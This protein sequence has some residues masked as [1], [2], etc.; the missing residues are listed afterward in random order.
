MP[1]QCDADI[2]ISAED[3]AHLI[4]QQF[5]ELAP[6]Q[7][8]QLGIGWHNAAFQVNQLFVFGFPRRM[9]AAKLLDREIR[10]LPLLAPRLPLSISSPIYTGEQTVAFPYRF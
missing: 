10:I 5:P 4:E 8:T 6:V 3:V 2:H 1:Q 9:V 7:L